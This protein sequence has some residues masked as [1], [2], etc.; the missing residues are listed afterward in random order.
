MTKPITHFVVSKSDNG[1]YQVHVEAGDGE[2]A[3]DFRIAPSLTQS[4]PSPL[5]GEL[6][7]LAATL[8]AERAN[9]KWP[10]WEGVAAH[11][12]DKFDRLFTL[13]PAVV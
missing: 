8:I 11:N 9:L 12:E 2:Y 6:R 7:A 1:D 5:R 4:E 13:I 10:S 3:G